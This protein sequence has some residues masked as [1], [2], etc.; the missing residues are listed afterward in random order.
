M[1]TFLQHDT[2]LFGED[3]SFPL[4]RS[5]VAPTVSPLCVAWID[6]CRMTR[7]CFATAAPALQPSLTLIPFPSLDDF[8][9]H[10]ASAIDV[11]VYYLHD[12]GRDPTG[13]ILMVRKAIPHLGLVFIADLS[14]VDR[15]SLL[16]SFDEG[17]VAFIQPQKASLQLVISALYLIHDERAFSFADILTVVPH[18]GGPGAH[19]GMRFGANLTQRERCVLELIRQGRSDTDIALVL[20]ITPGAVAAQIRKIMQKTRTRNRSQLALDTAR[21]GPGESRRWV[22]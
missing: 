20:R 8:L 16:K 1:G 9:P 13:E 17:M 21:Q 4:A 3:A 22:S 15:P 5:T 10:A 6:R 18:G 14:Q 11:V 2:P 12:A 7:E 19:R